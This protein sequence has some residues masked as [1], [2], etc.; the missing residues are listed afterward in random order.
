VFVRGGHWTDYG[1][2]FALNSPWFDS[3]VIAAHNINPAYNAAV[4]VHHPGRSV[5]YYV[6]GRFTRER[7]PP[8]ENN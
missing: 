4:Q 5:W 7:P 8:S 1:L 2:L 6:D 3:P